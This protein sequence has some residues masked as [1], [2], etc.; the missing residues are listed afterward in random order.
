M[1][2]AVGADGTLYVSDQGNARIQEFD[3]AGNLIGG[4]PLRATGGGVP[5]APGAL[6]V[7]P[8]GTLYVV[9]NANAVV[10]HLNRVGQPLG[11]WGGSGHGNGQFD[12]PGG[13]AADARGHLWVA[14]T[15]N[16]RVVE[17]DR[18]GRVQ[19]TFVSGVTAEGGRTISL[20]WPTGVSVRPDGG[21]AVADSG[22][23]RVVFAHPQ[24]Y[25]GSLS[26]AGMAQPAGLAVAPDGTYYVSDARANR[27]VHL[28]ADGGRL[29]AF[30][31]RGAGRG[32][33]NT[34]RGLA[35]GPDGNLYV[36][37]SGN[38]RIAVMTIA[39]GVVRYLGRRGHKPGQ[40]SDPRAV[41]VAADGTLWVAD[42]GNGRVQ[43]LSATG[44]VLGGGGV[45]VNGAWGVV[46]DGQGGVYYTE[47]WGQSVDHV[48]RDGRRQEWGAPGSGTEQFNHPGA[49][50]LADD[51]RTLYVVDEDNHRVQVI[52]DGQFVGHRGSASAAEAGLGLPAGVAITPGGAVVVLDAGRRRLAQYRN[53]GDDRVS[54]ATLS[55]I[56]LGLANASE[57][58]AVALY[59]QWTGA[60]EQQILTIV[61]AGAA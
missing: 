51:G 15:L 8:D 31:R 47:H 55:D 30:G 36:A 32:Q 28:D 16:N 52:R 4:F 33:F 45:G 50:T 34:P 2:V 13:I 40:F 20:R 42:E 21:I 1:G 9:D 29:G 38:D 41:S 39:G 46:A 48:D 26:L 61:A 17:L 37:D 22:H 5:P 27:V 14:D 60:T 24:P 44:A 19:S 25:L 12:G 59:G 54:T 35:F 23:D 58:V 49:L 43:H 10:L 7:A 18:S 53:V 56:P 3:L 6:T 57:G 11:R